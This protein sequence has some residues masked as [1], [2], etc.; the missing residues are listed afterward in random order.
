MFEV[1]IQDAPHRCPEVDCPH[2]HAQFAVSITERI[3]VCVCSDG[4][5][6]PSACIASL[7]NQCI[8]QPGLGFVVIL[9][10]NSERGS[11]L[12]IFATRLPADPRVICEHEPRAGIPFA[13]N[14]AIRAAI[15]LRCN[16]LA[17]IDDDE[18][19][20][21][22]WLQTLHSNLIKS[23]A[24]VIHGRLVRVPTLEAAVRQSRNYVPA[25]ERIKRRRTAATNNV[26]FRAWLVTPPLNL[27]F[28]EALA[29]VGGSDTEFFMRANDAGATIVRSSQPPV[30]EIWDEQRETINFIMKRAWRCGASAN[31]RYRKNRPAI[32]ATSVLLA[33]SAWR[34][35]GGAAQCAVGSPLCLLASSKGTAMFRKGLSSLSFA[36]GCLTPYASLRPTKYY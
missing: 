18:V 23:G 13:R 22:R 31:Y 26:L 21:D 30:F 7:V 5:R 36:A 28:D 25:E 24:D 8:N 15:R 4:R 32:V 27:M 6:D 2:S 35:A 33:R 17:Y 12:S 14:A 10:D 34:F 11:L 19:A 29:Q 3:A 20:P 16:F 1:R 9:I